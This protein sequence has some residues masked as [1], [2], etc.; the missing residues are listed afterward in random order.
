MNKEVKQHM[1]QAI[2]KLAQNLNHKDQDEIAQETNIFKILKV[3]Q[4]EIR[5]GAFLEFL[6]DPERN[7]ELAEFFLQ[8]WLKEIV[9][10]LVLQ[11]EQ[12]D[13]IIEGDYEK[14]GHINEVNQYSEIP[15]NNKGN[16]NRIDHALEVSLKN[17]CRVL[18]FEYKHNG[19]LQNDL[20][21]YKNYV[22][23][24]YKGKRAEIYCFVLE[25]GN[26]SHDKTVTE[27]WHFI[28][29]ETLI[30][31]ISETLREACRKD[32]QATRLYL[33]HYLQVLQPDPEDYELLK[34]F[35]AE[36]WD[37]WNPEVAQEDPDAEYFEEL[38]E[39]HVGS[40]HYKNLLS[41]F[42]Y[43]LL[44]D[45]AVAEA[46]QS[47]GNVT[48]RVNDGWVRLKL[49]NNYKNLYL[50]TYLHEEENGQ[51]YMAIKLRSW[52]DTKIPEQ[53]SKAQYGFLRD[54]LSQHPS[55]KKSLNELSDPDDLR[56]ITLVKDGDTLLKRNHPNGCKTPFDLSLTWLWP[57]DQQTFK[58]ISTQEKPQIFKEWIEELEWLAK[59]LS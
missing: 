15:L 26:K 13:K 42:N 49:N 19:V 25:L 2:K 34:G 3:D 44:F 33:E 35:R 23:G 57:I 31:A 30:N 45:W 12:L 48:V 41:S 55:I 18:V 59:A 8:T 24:Q 51:I 20:I 28:S 21:A 4:H 22:E 39:K 40:E 16:I 17:T 37:L 14:V 47:I 10:E 54:A 6:L 11:D 56:Y 58:A 38:L 52:H 29:R 9:S 7:P 43:Y 27:G 32:M 53:E 1:E 36:L 46:A 50:F 5:H